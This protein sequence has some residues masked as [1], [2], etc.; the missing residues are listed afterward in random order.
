MTREDHEVRE[1][2]VRETPKDVVALMWDYS[3][4]YLL[5]WHRHERAQL[6]YPSTGVITV[7]TPRSAWIATPEKALL[8]PAGLDHQVKMR[9]V[10]EMRSLFLTQSA[11]PRVS[12]ECALV[13]VSSM[14]RELLRHA[15]HLPKEYDEQGADGRLIKVILDQVDLTSSRAVSL[16]QPSDEKIRWIERHLIDSPADKRSIEDWANLVNVSSRTLAR[17]FQEDIKMPFRDWRQRLRLLAAIRLLA[18]GHS[19]TQTA[20]DVGFS[21]TSA[22]IAYFKQ[23]TGQTPGGYF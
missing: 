20:H 16:P 3:N 17:R 9:G 8:I 1:T 12:T 19:V 4:G 5:D 22:F 11:L 7:R 2:L 23:A 14:L 15:V 18:D 10:V 6:L 21:N 13:N